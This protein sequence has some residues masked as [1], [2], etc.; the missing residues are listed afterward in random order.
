MGRAVTGK[1]LLEV[2]FGSHLYGTDTPDSDL[3]IKRIYVP[4]AREIVLGSYDKAIVTSRKKAT[5]ERNSQDDVD[6]EQFSLDRFLHDL[7][8]GQTWA[9]DVLFAFGNKRA[10]CPTALGQRVMQQILDGRDRLLSRNVNAFVGYAR[11]QAARYGIKGSRMDAVRRVVD[12]L[13]ALPVSDRLSEHAVAI[14]ALVVDC[15]SLLSLEQ[16]QLIELIDLPGVNGTTVTHLH[17]CGRKLPL[18]AT[19]KY[20]RETYGKVLA[21]YG[22]RAKKA[23]LAGGVDWK[24]LSHAVRVNEEA[25]EVLDTGWITFPRPDRALLVQIKTGQCERHDVY[26]MIEQGLARLYASSASSDL[27]AEPDR[28]FADDLIY[29]VYRDEVLH[30]PR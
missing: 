16:S 5:F 13:N 28:A 20:A 12:L 17:V 29:N 11:K 27:R 1:V 18:G 4:T 8:D 25:V 26:T 15:E 30:G 2:K 10:E 14:G 21:E 23:H 7:M 19:V 24:A 6:V 22:E 9:L 3:D